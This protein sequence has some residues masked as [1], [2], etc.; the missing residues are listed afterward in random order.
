[1]A[2]CCIAEEVLL[3]LSEGAGEDL[4][5]AT[6]SACVSLLHRGTGGWS[7]PRKLHSWPGAHQTQ[8]HP[9][10]AP[11]NRRGWGRS[12]PCLLPPDG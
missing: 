2:P 8:R 1:M 9:R 10:P 12:P 5:E 11:S 7:S 4:K 3:K 6:R